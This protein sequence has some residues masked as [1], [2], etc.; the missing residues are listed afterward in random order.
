MT[1]PF[2][3]PAN[4][5]P[6]LP[7]PGFSGPLAGLL[8]LLLAGCGVPIGVKQANPQVVHR[9]L[10]ADVLSSGELSVP[11]WNRL[12]AHGLDERWKEN[13]Q[14]AINLMQ[15]DLNGANSTSGDYFALA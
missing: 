10:T 14:L 2:W 15:R 1:P 4:S 12:R 8:V 6:L 5:A 11:T 9:R 7:R 13:P 3:R